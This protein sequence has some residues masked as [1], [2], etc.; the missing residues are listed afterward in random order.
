[1]NKLKKVV[2]LLDMIRVFYCTN[3]SKYINISSCRGKLV[4]DLA[5]LQE[6]ILVYTLVKLYNK[7]NV[8]YNI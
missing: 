6:G 7:A 1:M 3:T 2:V 8:S 5:H 4:F